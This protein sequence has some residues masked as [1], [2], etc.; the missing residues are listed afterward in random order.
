[1]Q[2]VVKYEELKIHNFDNADGNA[3]G[4]QLGD[5]CDREHQATDRE[6]EESAPER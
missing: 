6:E 5:D 2:R 3:Q 1:M 4:S